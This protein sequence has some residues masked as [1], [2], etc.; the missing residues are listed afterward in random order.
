MYQFQIRVKDA[1]AGWQYDPK[2][3]EFQ[4]AKLLHKRNKKKRVHKEDALA[5]EVVASIM[6][7]STNSR[8]SSSV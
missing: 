3:M 4:H 5:V 6:I 2:A 8:L 1:D 7:P